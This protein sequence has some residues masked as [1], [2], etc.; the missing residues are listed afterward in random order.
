MW[1]VRPG[2]TTTGVTPRD[3]GHRATAP[4]PPRSPPRG[5]PVQSPTV[6]PA[7]QPGT[8][9]DGPPPRGRGGGAERGTPAVPDPADTPTPAA[10]AEP[11]AALAGE[12]EE[13]GPRTLAELVAECGPLS[14]ADAADC[15]EHLCDLLA[16]CD[17]VPPVG[18]HTVLVDDDGE[19]SLLPA[20]PRDGD[21]AAGERA[22]AGLR[23]VWCLL[24]TGDA[25][26]TTA[27]PPPAP[28][29]VRFDDFGGPPGVPPV[30]P[31]DAAPAPPPASDPTP[32]APPPAGESPPA[33]GRI[34][35]T[36]VD[37]RVW[38]IAAVLAASA[39]V[40]G[41]LVLGG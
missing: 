11:L 9:S 28:L 1:P 30:P 33:P 24:T 26:A 7:P 10:V 5:R 14:P 21:S 12:A 22:G 13:D 32:A 34:A 4:H 38:W 8:G 25:G 15:C 20:A 3:P 18:P 2:D 41:L 31:R 36:A 29:G 19:L 27:A 16:A 6:P 23:R 37:R 17:P 39:A 40:G 35:A